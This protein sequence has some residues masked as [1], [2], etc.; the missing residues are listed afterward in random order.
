MFH[1]ESCLKSHHVGRAPDAPKP[2]QIAFLP[3]EAVAAAPVRSA[4]AAMLL[5]LFL[6]LCDENMKGCSH[7]CEEGRVG[8][9]SHPPSAGKLIPPLSQR[10]D[11]PAEQLMPT[12]SG[13]TMH[14]G[15][16]KFSLLFPI[17]S[18]LCLSPL[19]RQT[20][21]E[22]SAQNLG[23]GWRSGKGDFPFSEH[24]HSPWGLFFHCRAEGPSP[25]LA[26]N[27]GRN[28]A[29]PCFKTKHGFFWLKQMT[30]ES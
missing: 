12:A 3:T 30:Q 10:H 17:C 22:V 8:P 7:S 19:L 28:E 11:F 16:F 1:S 9:A 5:R 23:V 24:Y 6:H 2:T 26:A 25:H 13:F 20:M 18:V 4:G 21:T 27:Q 29:C 14:Q 15:N